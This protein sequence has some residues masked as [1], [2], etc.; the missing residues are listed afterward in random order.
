MALTGP[1]RNISRDQEGQDVLLSCQYFP[2][3]PGWF[4]V[5]A[6]LG[7]MPVRLVTS[8]PW[9]LASLRLPGT[10]HIY[11]Q[12]Q[13]FIGSGLFMYLPMTATP[14]ASDY[15]CPSGCFTVLN[16]GHH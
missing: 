7:R 9:R 10:N 11:Q 13:I 5:S 8:Q 15:L 12:V 16:P 6:L 3:Y 2:I 4:E 14:R 1:W